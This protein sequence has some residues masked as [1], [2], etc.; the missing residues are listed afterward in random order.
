[1]G[2]V[3]FVVG[4]VSDLLHVRKQRSV[5]LWNMMLKHSVVR[6]QKSYQYQESIDERAILDWVN[7]SKTLIVSVIISLPP[8][9]V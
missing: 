5:F 8:S 7:W 1:M 2:M 9:V 6:M 4:R 3:I